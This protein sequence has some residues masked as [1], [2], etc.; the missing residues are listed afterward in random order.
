MDDNLFFEPLD[1][2][3]CQY[4]GASSARNKNRAGNRAAIRRSI[5]AL[6]RTKKSFIRS[7]KKLIK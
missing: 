2:F 6:N 1:L 7:A 3:I 5:S 4:G